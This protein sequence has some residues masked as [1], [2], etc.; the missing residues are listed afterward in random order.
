MK[1]AGYFGTPKPNVY[2]FKWGRLGW[3]G[4]A[5]SYPNTKPI[6]ALPIATPGP[7]GLPTYGDV[8]AA[9]S[10]GETVKANITPA[11]AAELIRC[12]A[13]GVMQVVGGDNAGGDWWVST[14]WGST[15]DALY[16]PIDVRDTVPAGEYIYSNT[17]TPYLPERTQRTVQFYRRLRKPADA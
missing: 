7:F 10:T 13:N 1:E 17:S 4:A 14:L 6:G 2:S 3:N 16:R 15:S 9:C 11:M 5:Q 12:V 8:W